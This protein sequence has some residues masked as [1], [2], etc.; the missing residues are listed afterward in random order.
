[1]NCPKC[2]NEV[3]E[4][5][6]FC[7]KCGTQL[8]LSGPV[9]PSCGAAVT[10]GKKFCGKC[11][12]PIVDPAEKNKKEVI[13]NAG[14]IYW[15]I[16]EGQ[17]ACKIDEKELAHYKDIKGF[18]VQEGTKA[19]FFA[20]GVFAGELQGGKYPFKDF[21]MEEE[22]GIKGFFNKV[23]NFFTGKGSSLIENAAAISII[24][25][26]DAAFPLIFTEQDMP[27]AGI[28]SEVA[29]HLLAKISNIIQFYKSLLLDSDFV[30]FEKIAGSLK[31]VIRT[32]LE[33]AVTGVDPATL[34]SNADARQKVFA[35]VK[36]S[37]A[38]I[39]PFISVENIIRLTATNA[40]LEELRQLQEELYVSEQEL[41]QLSR[42]NS[43]LQRL[44]DEQNQQALNEA[45]TQA[46]FAAAMNTIDQ[47]NELL[48]DEKARFAD[49]LYWQRRLREAQSE[50]EGE[51][52]LHKLEQNGLLREEEI[53]V[54]KSDISQRRKLKDLNDSQTIA[55]LTL[56]NNRALDAEKLKWEMEIG[57]KRI[58]NQLDRQRMQD[59]YSDSRRKADAEFEDSRRRADLEYEREQD[60]MQAE[61]LREAMRV[62]NEMEDAEHRRKMEEANA[63][64]AFE[65]DKEK[66]QHRSE[67]EMRR[68]FMNMSAEQIMAANPDISPAAAAALAE[69]FK[70][71]NAQEAIQREKEHAA[72]I[73]RIMSQ[74]AQNQQATMDKMF[75]MMSGFVANQNAQKDEA[76][77][78]ARREA[79][80]IRRDANEHQDRM[81]E[82]IQTQ[83][84]ASYG[85]AG[86]IY[87]PPVQNITNNGNNRKDVPANICPSCGEALNPGASFCENCGQSL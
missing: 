16:L 86:K 25:I 3:A 18:V 80:D 79:A 76:L 54:L 19:L 36:N 44:T 63:A 24:I 68:M 32:A 45:Q 21:G 73:E 87:A 13:E 66:E 69:K 20:D 43:F 7:G 50:D 56:Q 53:E 47:Q 71:Q 34:S 72:D 27:T 11:G 75:A 77:Q 31:T 8:Q 52:A 41:V 67:E 2:G 48:D 57:N 40:E 15:K 85:A 12:A 39:Y 49:M 5:K 42:R 22:K 82:I 60:R 10:P 30:S 81:S 33:D 46:D 6:K 65:L 1:M 28:R 9:C 4:G 29:V 58:Q 74:N 78:N 17:L 14:F 84:N 59:E 55:M 83:A 23:K 61:Q 37:V 51:A 38:S 64:R 35:V 26:R 62:K 70:G